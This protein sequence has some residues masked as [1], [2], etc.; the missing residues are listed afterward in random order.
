[1]SN[2]VSKYFD[3]FSNANSTKGNLGDFQHASRLYIDNNMRLAP[4]FSH[5][6]HVV[7][8]INPNANIAD[9]N[10]SIKYEINLLAKEADLPRYNVD[11]QVI[12]Q[13]NRKKMIQ[14]GIQYS[15]INILFHD[16][17]AGLTTLLWEAYFRYY[18]ADGDYTNSNIDGSEYIDAVGYNRISA[19][20]NN[21]Y[22]SSDI[23]TRFKYGLDKPNKTTPF[24]TSIQIYQLH[25]EGGRARYTSFT[26]INPIIDQFQ[27]DR[28]SNDG[29]N[30]SQ[31]TLTISY[32]SVQYGRGYTQVGL[33][34]TGFGE[35]HYDK[36]PSPLGTAPD[37][38]SKF[39]N[40]ISKIAGLANDIDR[41]KHGNLLNFTNATSNVLNTITSLSQSS[42]KANSSNILSN[43][44]NNLLNN[45]IFPVTSITQNVKTITSAIQRI[46]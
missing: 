34:P 6:F 42:I 7:L 25:P 18:Y 11:S 13:Y 35:Y 24:F 3:N 46:F 23:F 38:L 14:T 30:L 20:L 28:V 21:V 16:D 22:G 27:H 26:L 31:N 2:F 10:S 29:S 19:G 37:D 41:F 45:I 43:V 40:V 39:T 33:S 5:L 17:N 1:M 8:N 4:K 44:T 12:N 32:E 36:I 15:P 9:L